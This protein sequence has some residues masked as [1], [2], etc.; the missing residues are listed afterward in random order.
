MVAGYRGTRFAMYGCP[1]IFNTDQG[2]QF[3]GADFTGMLKNHGLA[4]SMDGRGAWRDNV[5]VERFWRSI[6]Y[7]EVYLRA[8]DSAEEAEHFIGRYI[9][10]RRTAPSLVARRQ[11][12]ER[13]I[14]HK[15]LR[16]A[17]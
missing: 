13:G 14:L 17:A 5:M 9:S 1:A 3:T 8:Y 11:N 16:K 4:V 2:S 7:E 15:P 12:A 10:F 6:K